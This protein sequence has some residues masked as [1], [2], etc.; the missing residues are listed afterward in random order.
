MCLLVC[1]MFAAFTAS[2]QLVIT[3]SCWFCCCRIR[4]SAHGANATIYMYNVSLQCCKSLCASELLYSSSSFLFLPHCVCLCSLQCV[5]VVP[6]CVVVCVCVWWWWGGVSGSEWQVQGS[7]RRPEADRGA[8]TLAAAINHPAKCF[9]RAEEGKRRASCLCILHWTHA[10][11]CEKERT[12][13]THKHTHT[14]K[15]I[16]QG[17][18]KSSGR[19]IQDLRICF[20]VSFLFPI[21]YF[22]INIIPPWLSIKQGFVII[23]LVWEFERLIRLLQELADEMF[24][25]QSAQSVKAD[26]RLWSTGVTTRQWGL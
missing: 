13:I 20:S 10:C 3:F 19:R 26:C 23:C 11:L 14:A 5:H 17:S 18:T 9:W 6:V 7:W 21:A 1:C 15:G 24:T 22:F 4:Y 8:W 2:H 12:G 25:D 16:W